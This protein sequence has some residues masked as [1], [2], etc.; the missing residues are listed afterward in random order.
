MYNIYLATTFAG[1]LICLLTSLLLFFR[2]KD[3]ERSRS[4]LAWIV[5]F[6]VFNYLTRFISLSNGE[7]PQ[8]VVSVPML[9]LAIFMVISYIMYPIEVISPGWLNFRR[10]IKLCS[11]CIILLGIYLISLWA[12]VEYIPYNSL[13]DMFP[14]AGQ[15]DVWFRLMLAFLIFTPIL[16]IFFIPYTR[17]YNNTDYVWIRKYVIALSINCLAY[18]LVLTFDTPVVRTLYY[19]VSVG[20]SL[21]ISYMELFVRLIG[22]PVVK[23]TITQK[24]EEPLPLY[25]EPVSKSK[26]AVLIDKLNAYMAKTCAWRDPDLSLN[27]LAQALCTNRTTL[28][29]VM[30]E[31]GYDSYTTYV[32]NLRIGDFLKQVESKQSVNFQEAFF[33]AGFR[34]RATALR[35]FRQITGM[36]PSEYFQKN[37]GKIR[38]E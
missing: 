9:L 33:D 15:F 5:L 11:L 19:Y 13:L 4:I 27:T 18:I 8:L 12:K 10:I 30:Q 37:N 14:H 24:V 31:N 23:E 35:N 17:R 21:F 32:N 6:S 26:N 20:C 2:R 3:G 36:T 7:I 25:G 16:F 1:A 38:R 28:T 34:S 29:Q 22:K